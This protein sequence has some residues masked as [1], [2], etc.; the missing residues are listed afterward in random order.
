MK[1][2]K[3]KWNGKGKGS[4]R[5]MQKRFKTEDKVIAKSRVKVIGQYVTMLEARQKSG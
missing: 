5:K 2:G 1:R 3:T 4:E